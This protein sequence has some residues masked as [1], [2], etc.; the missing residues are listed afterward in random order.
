MARVGFRQVANRFGHVDGTFV[1]AMLGWSQ[2]PSYFCFRYFPWFEHPLYR[3]AVQKKEPWGFGYDDD[4]LKEVGV[5]PIDL[6][7]F[8]LTAV[9]N[10]IDLG[11]TSEH[12]LLWEHEEE[13]QLFINQPIDLS[14]MGQ[15]LV[16]QF[17]VAARSSPR[18]Q[19]LLGDEGRALGAQRSF[20]LSLPRTLHLAARAYLDRAGTSYFVPRELGARDMP[21]LFSIDDTSYIIARDFEVDMPEFEFKPEWF[22]PSP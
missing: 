3:A 1:E 5:H 17:G 16:E 8:R 19:P 6:I 4:A 12:P 21:W 2:L 9:P 13:A 18:L 22:K 20:A 10:C 15:A 11:F 7:E 14:A